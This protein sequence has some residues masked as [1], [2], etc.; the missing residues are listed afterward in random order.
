MIRR[1]THTFASRRREA[2]TFRKMAKRKQQPK[3][4]GEVEGIQP[5]LGGFI[6]F[7]VLW[8]G[9][10][11]GSPAALF[12]SEVSA[13]WFI[14]THRGE[15]VAAQAI[16]IHCN[17]TLVHPDRFA[18]VVQRAALAAAGKALARVSP[19]QGARNDDA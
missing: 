9:G 2:P 18:A 7:A 11:P 3:E 17:K 10:A 19:V 16:A 15:L 12:P 13:R 1:R 6:P 14:R 5:I 8:D 4:A